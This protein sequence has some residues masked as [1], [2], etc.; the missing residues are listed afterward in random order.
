[1]GAANFIAQKVQNGNV[2]VSNRLLRA[3]SSK[4]THDKY[5]CVAVLGAPE[6]GDIKRRPK[7]KAR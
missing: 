3:V 2:T 4:Y 6:V 5:N 1:M 7:R